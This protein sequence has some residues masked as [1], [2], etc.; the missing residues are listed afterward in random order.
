MERDNDCM[1]VIRDRDNRRY[2]EKKKKKKEK[3]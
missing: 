3:E 1:E 2:N